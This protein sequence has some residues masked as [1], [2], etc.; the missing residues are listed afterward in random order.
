MTERPT[1]RVSAASLN[2]SES[3]FLTSCQ[4]RPMREF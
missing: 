2:R 4:L 3:A 1:F